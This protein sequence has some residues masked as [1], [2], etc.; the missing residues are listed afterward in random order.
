MAGP[1]IIISFTTYPARIHTIG[2]VVNC[3]LRQTMIPDKIILYLAESQFPDRKLP[4]G[5]NI[6]ENH[7]FE[8]RWC[9]EDLGPHKKYFYAMQEFP[10]DIVITVDDDFYYANTLVSELVY[11][12]KKF[13]HAVIARRTRIMTCMED[14]TLAPYQEWS[15][16]CASYAY[17]PR[18]DLCAGGGGGVLY[19]PHVLGTETFSSNYF[20]SECR[21]ADD[22][23]LK[24]MEVLYGIPVIVTREN[25]DDTPMAEYSN[26]GLFQHFNGGDGNNRQI[27]NVLRKYNEYYG[28]DDTLLGRIFAK[29][30]VLAPSIIF[31][32]ELTEKKKIL[33][34][35]LE[36]SRYIVIYGAG[37]VGKRV[38]KFL[39]ESGLCHKLLAF[40]VS[41]INGNPDEI[42][43]YPVKNYREYS[44]VPDI[45]YV[46]GLSYDKQDEVAIGLAK[47]NVVEE[48]I[49][50]LDKMTNI[51]LARF[52]DKEK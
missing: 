46:I 31:N 43:G 24:F 27:Q 15:L 9:K 44:C 2:R 17:T 42:E 50:R 29:G 37:T 13:P 35:N 30:K 39:E 38:Y 16:N 1:K 8:I 48:R 10:E 12:H 6:Y 34:K 11:W 23:W 5:I 45:N 21:H 20:M 22:I 47:V 3:M 49:I 32:K 41:D 25:F 14:G 28:T 33:L 52:M 51:V 18:M 7:G 4:V 40:V 19:P 26:D 36:K